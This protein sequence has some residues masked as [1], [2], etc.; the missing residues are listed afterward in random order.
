[1]L[2]D[3]EEVVNIC[4]KY[5][6]KTIKKKGYPLYKGREMTKEDISEI[7]YSPIIDNEISFNANFSYTNQ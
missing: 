6:I 7:M 3:E 2:Y 4:K 5:G 1:M